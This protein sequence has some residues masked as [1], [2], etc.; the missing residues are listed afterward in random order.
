MITN[1]TYHIG[2]FTFFITW[3]GETGVDQKGCT[4]IKVNGEPQLKNKKVE[5]TYTLANAEIHE[6]RIKE[7]NSELSANDEAYFT[8]L[9]TLS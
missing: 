8:Q 6:R 5:D 9:K 2:Y 4:W 3:T 7:L 1:T